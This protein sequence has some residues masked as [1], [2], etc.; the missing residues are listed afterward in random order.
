[1]QKLSKTVIKKVNSNCIKPL[2]IKIAMCI[3]ILVAFKTFERNPFRLVD[4][5]SFFCSE[6]GLEV[7]SVAKDKIAEPTATDPA[8]FAFG[9]TAHQSHP[10]LQQGLLQSLPRRVGSRLGRQ[11]QPL[12]RFNSGSNLIL[13]SNSRVY[14]FLL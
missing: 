6:S 2:L 4:R 7:D 9:R 13:L 8:D 12:V 11:N 1:M 10:G 5:T 14:R 3:I